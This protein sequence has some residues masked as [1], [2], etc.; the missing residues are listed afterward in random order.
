MLYWA[1]GAKERN[2]VRF[3][4]SDQEMS[5]HF[6]RFL[7]NS[8]G[9]RS[10]QITLRLNVYLNNGLTIREIEDR[11]LRK[12]E[13]PRTCLRKHSINHYPTSTSGMRRHKLPYGVCTVTVNRT[14]IVQHIFG[15]IQEYGGFAEL[16]WLD[17]PPRPQRAAAR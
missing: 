11:W 12:L 9:V 15:A 8:L 13:L 17:G 14:R 6:V 16:R 1:E 7:R 2:A 4:N 10:E 3:V 5:C